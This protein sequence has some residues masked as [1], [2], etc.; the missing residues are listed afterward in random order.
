MGYR[1]KAPKLN[2]GIPMKKFLSLFLT[3][4]L[5]CAL[6]PSAAASTIYT[7]KEIKVK[8]DFQTEGVDD[9]KGSATYV[10]V[11]GGC[12]SSPWKYDVENI[13]LTVTYKG[14]DYKVKTKDLELEGLKDVK[15]SVFELFDKLQ[16]IPPRQRQDIFRTV[17]KGKTFIQREG[18]VCAGNPG[19]VSCTV[20]IK[21]FAERLYR[22][23][24]LRIA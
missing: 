14:E 10:D 8:H 17:K 12:Y 16:N 13:S 21:K 18:R 20:S 24:N 4:A 1:R 6:L 3:L 11:E 19:G 15:I 22:S 5:L 23:V 7:A 9:G 2:G